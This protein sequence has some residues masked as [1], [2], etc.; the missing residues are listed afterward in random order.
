KRFIRAIGRR[1]YWLGTHDSSG[2]KPAQVHASCDEIAHLRTALRRSIKWCIAHLAIRNRDF[3]SIPEVAQLLLVELLLLVSNVLA[4][5]SLAQAVSLDSACENDGW[6]AL[7]FDG[8]LK[9]RINLD[10]I[11]TAQSQFP[12]PLVAEMVHEL[13]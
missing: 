1:L 11:V 10:R 6:L 13:H 12:K 3:K 5:A 2:N 7:M 9:C 4:F 8:R